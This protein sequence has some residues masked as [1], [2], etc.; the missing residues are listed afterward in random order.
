M[1]D[2]PA[3]AGVL[4]KH[5]LT[6]ALAFAGL[7]LVIIASAVWVFWPGIPT[8]D[9]VLQYRQLVSGQIDDWHPPVMARVWQLLNPISP[10]TGPLFALQM[11]LYGIGFALVIAALV[12]A[13]RPK[14][15]LAAG[16]F[17]MSPLLLG[18]QIVVM[19]DE[20][21]LGALVAAFSIVAAYRLTGK[22]VPV[23]AGLLAA[24]LLVY[25][26]LL[27]GNAVF[28]TVPLTM[29][30]LPRPNS[31]RVRCILGIVAMVGLLVLSP[32]IQ[33]ALFDAKPSSRLKTQP[34][35]DLAGISSRTPA[36]PLPFTAAERSQLVERH[37]SNSFFWDSLGGLGPC[38]DVTARVRASSSS[39]LTIALARN[40][41]RH[42]LA[43]AEHRL[44]HWN[45]TERWWVPLGLISADPQIKA[46]P[47]GLGLRGPTSVPKWWQRLAHAQ[48]AT[49]LGWPIVWTTLALFFLPVAFRRRDAA[50][51]LALALLGSG[52]VLELSFLV[53]S[54]ASELRY[55]L[56]PMTATVLALV[57]LS[58]KLRSALKPIHSIAL[59]AVIMTGTLAREILPHAPGTYWQMVRN[60]TGSA[61]T[62]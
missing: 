32:P 55:H 8:Y 39:E 52:L 53:V 18:W 47:N 46:H 45:M 5:S 3:P 23:W 56:W 61:S 1:D 20:Q 25:A 34:L 11:L 50:G 13:G 16:L 43:Y 51:N 33:R 58:D 2:R 22:A 48:A 7:F 26:T 31:W 4:P 19:K 12:R 21:M 10:G 44:A 36:D 29:L 15:A 35:F 17:G 37:C 9:S 54:I 28:A 38:A 6:A 40:V 42:P 62:Q 30:L 49:P 14:A 60:P 57:L 41:M 24:L 27:R 59:L